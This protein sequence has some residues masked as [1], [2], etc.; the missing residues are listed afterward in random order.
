MGGDRVASSVICALALLIFLMAALAVL[1]IAT[2]P[3]RNI[4]AV[5]AI[6]ASLAII[7]GHRYAVRNA[8]RRGRRAY[9]DEMRAALE[10]AEADARAEMVYP[11]AAD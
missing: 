10:R 3:I 5:V 11:V 2:L 8:Y 7:V 9:R 6:F 4:F 1:G